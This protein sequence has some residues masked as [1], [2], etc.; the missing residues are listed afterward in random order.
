[1]LSSVG[2][3][4]AHVSTPALLPSLAPA[5]PE[6]LGKVERRATRDGLSLVWAE[7]SSRRLGARRLGERLGPISESI[8]GCALK[9]WLRELNWAGEQMPSFTLCSIVLT[10]NCRV[11]NEFGAQWGRIATDTGD[12]F[13]DATLAIVRSVIG[14]RIDGV[15]ICKEGALIWG[16]G[17]EQACARRRAMPV[18][19]V[20]WEVGLGG[21]KACGKDKV[22]DIATLRQSAWD[23]EAEQDFKG[24]V[25][26]VMPLVISVSIHL[27]E[28]GAE[29]DTDAEADGEI[30]ADTDADAL[31]DIQAD[32]QADNDAEVVA[33]SGGVTA[34]TWSTVPVLTR[35]VSQQALPV[36]ATCARSSREACIT[37]FG[38]LVSHKITRKRR[39]RIWWQ[40][41]PRRKCND[42]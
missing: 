41:V 7:G 39:R 14:D 31:R 34:T 42:V 3:A 15:C 40:Y 11:A 19:V 27:S 4:T 28:L 8:L 37:M 20:T 6:G 36:D 24:V 25:C 12:N 38:E 22:W 21:G 9:V 35:V 10:A 23:K 1:M 2:L 33:A 16:R 13:G 32:T 26:M 18:E 30:D 5:V 17:R 29:T